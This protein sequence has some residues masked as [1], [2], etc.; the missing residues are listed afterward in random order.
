MSKFRIANLLQNYAKNL[1]VFHHSKHFPP[2]D[3]DAPIVRHISS[4]MSR[5]PSVVLPFYVYVTSAF[6]ISYVD[7]LL[8]LL[9]QQNRLFLINI[10]AC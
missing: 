7:T 3:R 6:D 5:L 2:L 1:P 8:S 10:S 9:M 4:L